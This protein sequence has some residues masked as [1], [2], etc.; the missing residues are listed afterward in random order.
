MCDRQI[1]TN[2]Y[3]LCPAFVTTYPVPHEEREAKP[4]EKINILLGQTSFQNSAFSLFIIIFFVTALFT[5][6]DLKV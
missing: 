4:T 3:L 2:V 1:M 5:H 6:P